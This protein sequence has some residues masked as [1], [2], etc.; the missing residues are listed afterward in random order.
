MI[1]IGLTGSIGMGKTTAAEMLTRLGVPVHDSD[2]E[3]HGLLMR[4]SAAWKDLRKAFPFFL[5]PQ[6]YKFRGGI[7]RKNLGRLV[8]ANKKDREKLE[9][10][11]HPQVRIAQDRFIS[12]HR[13]MGNDIVALDIPL[14]FETGAE[15]RVDTVINISAPAYIQEKRV[16]SRPGMTQDKFR[17]ILQTQMSDGEKCARADFVVH[18]GLG[19]A[20]MMKELKAVLVKIKKQHK[21][22]NAA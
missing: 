1:V 22:I 13:R 14:L 6:I 19:R 17:A 10:I 2:F 3:V 12:D 5:Y 9:S 20:Q 16:L 18:S 15:K 21:K 4:G 11:L 8:F 7:N